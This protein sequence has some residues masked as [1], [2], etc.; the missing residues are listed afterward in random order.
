M[1]PKTKTILKRTG[2]TLVALLVVGGLFW[3]GRASKKI[4]KTQIEIYRT[5]NKAYMVRVYNPDEEKGFSNRLEILDKDKAS[6]FFYTGT[7]EWKKRNKFEERNP[8]ISVYVDD[9]DK[10]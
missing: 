8:H 10:L 5:N 9:I 6:N 4:P 3:T 1:K 7:D 2:A